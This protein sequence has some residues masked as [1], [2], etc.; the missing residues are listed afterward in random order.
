MSQSK[1]RK[2]NRP[3]QVVGG[4][5]VWSLSGQLSVHRSGSTPPDTPYKA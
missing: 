4:V 3:I 2:N 1:D 5:L